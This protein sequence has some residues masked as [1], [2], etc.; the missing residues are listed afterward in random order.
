MSSTMSPNTPPPPLRLV[1]FDTEYTD[2]NLEGAR[3]LQIAAAITDPD[4]CRVHPAEEDLCMPVRLPEDATVSP[5]VAEHL[6]PLLAACRGPE[7][8]SLAEAETALFGLLDRAAAAV[9]GPVE[10]VLAGNSVH[11]D[12]WLARRDL[13]RFIARLH[14]RQ[15]D[16][17]AFKLE[18]RER[19]P[20]ELFEK[21]N[22]DMVRAWFPDA[23]LDGVVQH[24][25]RYDIQASIAELAF[26]RARLLQPR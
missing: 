1:W 6:A 3:I 7:A 26:Y 5:W 8:V 14:Y 24:D 2:L 16:V 21:D 17:T 4:L 15:L 10:F 25:A 9:E 20:A 11:A 18:W 23:R 22:A 19:Q 13:P 12:W